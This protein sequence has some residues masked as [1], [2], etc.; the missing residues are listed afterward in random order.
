MAETYFFKGQRISK[1]VAVYAQSGSAYYIVDTRDCACTEYLH[2]GLSVEPQCMQPRSLHTV[3][4]RVQLAET[5][6]HTQALSPSI[7]GNIWQPLCC[8]LYGW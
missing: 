7:E 2:W 8:G 1:V 6:G 4:L 3:L 5:G